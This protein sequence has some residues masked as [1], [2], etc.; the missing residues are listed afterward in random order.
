LAAKVFLIQSEGLGRGDETLGKTLMTTFLR[1]LSGSKD[2]PETIMFWNR[3]VRLLCEESE[4][5]GYIIKLQ[6][7]GVEI[8]GCS[9]CLEYFK[10]QDKMKVG[11]PT[12]MVK[13]VESMMNS[14]MVCL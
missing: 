6:G 2:K 7:Q 4:A 14:D 9:T 3:G 8:L 13:S 12:T 5:L 1:V 10:L 11:K